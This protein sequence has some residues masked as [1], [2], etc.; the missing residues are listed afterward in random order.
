VP[1][2]F[3]LVT[4]RRNP[5]PV[6]YCS[7]TEVTAYCSAPATETPTDLTTDQ[8]YQLAASLLSL[9][10]L[11]NLF[12]QLKLA[13]VSASISRSVWPWTH[14]KA[15]SKRPAHT[16]GNGGVERADLVSGGPRVVHAAHTEGRGEGY[17]PPLWYPHPSVS[18]GHKSWGWASTGRPG[19]TADSEPSRA[20]QGS[21]GALPPIDH[22]RL[23]DDCWRSST[24][25]G[26]AAGLRGKKTQP[27]ESVEGGE[28]HGAGSAAGAAGG[29]SAGPDGLLG[30]LAVGDSDREAAV[31]NDDVGGGAAGGGAEGVHAAQQVGAVDEAAED[32]VLAVEPARGGGGEEE[33]AG[34]GRGGAPASVGRA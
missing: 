7:R 23:P 13:P 8:T 6:A 20:A 14:F 25:A 34:A 1:L 4:T 16:R 17:G 33:L 18:K 11:L 31:A 19:W 22:G 15:I 12:R 10:K 9:L 2:R 3:E 26:P 32:D 30:L 27:S 24:A 5:R 28:T 29:G 21:P